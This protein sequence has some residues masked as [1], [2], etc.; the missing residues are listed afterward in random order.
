MG[1]VGGLVFVLVNAGPLPGAPVLRVLAGRGFAAVVV[2]VAR[3]RVVSPAP[4]A[5]A[6]RVY[7]LSVLAMVLAIIAGANVLTRLLDRS[8]LV[9]C[10]V[11]LVVGAHFVPFASAF[12]APVFTTLGLALVAVGLLGGVG[13]L[14]GVADA[15][16]WCGVVA[17]AVLLGAAAW[18]VARPGQEA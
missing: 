17:G 18:G 2:L 9:L 3:S 14:A 16:R 6:A 7:G 11:V 4:S 5:G 12:S 10:W 15:Q 13:V 1:A 8:D